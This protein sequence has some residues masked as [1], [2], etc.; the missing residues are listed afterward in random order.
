MTVAVTGAAG[1]VGVNLVAALAAAGQPVRVI[2]RRKPTAPPP[3]GVEWVV[4]DVRNQ[5]AMGRALS[6]VDVVYHLAAVISVAGPMSGLVHS[7]NVLGVKATAQA[8]LNS[9][10]RRFVH[11]SSVHAYD[12]MACKGRTVDENSPRSVNPTVPAY[13]RSKAAGEAALREVVDDGLEAVIINPTGVVGPIDPGPSR[14]GVVLRATAAG[15]LPAS[16]Q[17]SFDWVDVRDVV[18]ALIAASELGE[19]GENYLIGGRSATVAEIADLAAGATGAR[20]PVVDLPMWFARML[21]PLGD[22]AARLYPHPML[23]TSDT[24][25]ALASEPDVDHSKAA[26]VLGYEPRPLAVTVTELV[27]SLSS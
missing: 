18:A 26:R 11:C 23:Y 1:H 10:V 13:D 17:G 24:L 16:I 22:V 3:D 2:D 12:L 9:G 4:A 14:M 6:D 25:N 21:T 7:V 5:A 15:H 8:A 20:R 27:E 19:V